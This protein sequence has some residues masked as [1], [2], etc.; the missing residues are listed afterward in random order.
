MSKHDT[1]HVTPAG[2]SALLDLAAEEDAVELQMR[3]TLLRELGCWL[4]SSELTLIE[5][6]EVLGIAPAPVS[7]LKRGRISQFSLDTLTRLQ[8]KI[9]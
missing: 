4:A 9:C 8:R 6:A 5:A 3:S 2:R 7:D 1:K